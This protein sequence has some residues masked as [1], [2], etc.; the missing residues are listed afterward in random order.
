MYVDILIHAPLDSSGSLIRLLRSIE[1][2]DY[3]GSRRPHLTIEL[4]PETD[5]PTQQFLEH[6]VWPPIDPS[7]APRTSQV[8]LRHRIPRQSLSTEE[9]ASHFIE[10][11]YPARPAD[12]HV[13]V[14]SPQVELSPLY[15]HYIKYNLLEYRYSS[16]GQGG[17]TND[18]M[19]L[20]LELPSTHLND[21]APF[22]P[23]PSDIP[24]VTVTASKSTQTTPF[25][26]QAPNSNAA[27]YFGDKWI[28]LHSFLSN[29]IAAQKS[30]SP[31][32]QRPKQISKKYPSWMEYIL[33]LM[34]ARAY[35]LLYP[36]IP[37]SDSIVTVHNELYQ[38]P[39]EYMVQVQRPPPANGAQP[40]SDQQEPFTADP[41]THT[42]PSTHRE[43]PLLSSSLMSIL[44][45]AGELPKLD[46]LPL[47]SHTGQLITPADAYTLSTSFATDFKREV[48]GC[49][50]KRSLKPLLKI[51]RADDL[52]CFGNEEVVGDLEKKGEQKVDPEVEILKQGEGR[53]RNTGTEIK[54]VYGAPVVTKVDQ[55]EE[56]VA[57]EFAA[58]LVRQRGK[59]EN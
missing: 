13:L 55:A 50:E 51:W 39:E 40:S 48:G 58:H 29:R 30:D 23:P 37:S 57:A 8:T 46:S 5:P 17:S 20:S 11:F 12:S 59:R 14:L 34:R 10:S 54:R 47:L 25:L 27:L 24:I 26:W 44:P 21:S 31:P 43:R 41:A 35:T 15:Y 56:A 7:G 22:D 38:L 28:E 45:S 2:A 32:N 33:E 19:G 36:N 9:A 49:N 53:G 16:Y 42:S 6:L 4:P 3:F 1:Q 52:F 18:L